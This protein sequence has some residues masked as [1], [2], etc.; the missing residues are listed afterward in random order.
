MSIYKLTSSSTNGSR[1][2]FPMIVKVGSDLHGYVGSIPSKHT[3]AK[4]GDRTGGQRFLKLMVIVHIKIDKVWYY[5]HR[6][7]VVKYVHDE[8]HCGSN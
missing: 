1:N 3:K 8:W 7:S 6:L 4:V 2:C 5:E